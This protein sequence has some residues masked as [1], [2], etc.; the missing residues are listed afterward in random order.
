MRGAKLYWLLIVLVG[1]LLNSTA[2]LSNDSAA[3]LSVGGLRFT[4]TSEV[5]LEREELRLSIDRVEVRY[6]FTNMSGKPVTLTVAFPL[7]DIDLAEAENIALPSSDPINFV[8]FETTIDGVPAKF[9]INQ[10]AFVGQKDVSSILGRLKLPMLPIGNREI[11]VQSLPGATRDQLVSDGLLMPAGMSD[12]G[13]PNYS[14]GWIVKTSAVRQQTFPV[15]RSVSVEH[16]YRP[17]VG[18]SADTILRKSLRQNKALAT[19]VGRY[20]TEFCVTDSFLAEL[21]KLAGNSSKP[22]IQERR[23]NYILSTGANW[24]GPIKYFKL[25]IDPGATDRLVSFCPHGLKMIS[26]DGLEFAA[27]DF[28]PSADLKLLFI[29]RF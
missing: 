1:A 29:G 10:H 21:D 5:S 15:D 9:S 26:P 23:I 6:L 4:K 18:S 3:E 19:E 16:R 27:T 7:P 14:F 11:R 22:S 2:A 8:D 13:R 20:R 17:S 24:G 28:K 12:S 25:T